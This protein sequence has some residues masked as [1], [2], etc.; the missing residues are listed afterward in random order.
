MKFISCIE[1]T[2][3]EYVRNLLQGLSRGKGEFLVEGMRQRKGLQEEEAREGRGKPQLWNFT[4]PL[5][6]MGA[7][8]DCPLLF[9]D[10]RLAEVGALMVELGCSE[11]AHVYRN[12]RET[13]WSR[14]TVSQNQVDSPWSYVFTLYCMGN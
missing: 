3:G 13:S 11:E 5:L 6:C 9:S 14:L 7:C 1:F 4:S 2:M 8:M 10:H 12:V